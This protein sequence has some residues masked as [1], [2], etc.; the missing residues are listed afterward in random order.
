MHLQIQLGAWLR[1]IL[2]TLQDKNPPRVD[3]RTLKCTIRKVPQPGVPPPP[4]P[5]GEA[6]D[7]CIKPSE[8][9][10]NSSH[11]APGGN[12]TQVTLMGPEASAS[13]LHHSCFPLFLQ[14]CSSNA[15]VHY[16]LYI[17]LLRVQHCLFNPASLHYV[18][19]VIPPH[20]IG[21]FTK[22]VNLC[23]SFHIPSKDF[24]PH[25]SLKFPSSIFTVI[26]HG[27]IPILNI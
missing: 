10:D 1:Q 11:K 21:M 27:N 8:K 12:R 13:Q 9:G 23:V 17:P 3:T 14:V 24:I 15:V 19:P 7:K 18:W 4:R 20:S 26:L 2:G 6:D 5:L 22:R 25:S 16:T